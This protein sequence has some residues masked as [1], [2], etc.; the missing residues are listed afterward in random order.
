MLFSELSKIVGGEINHLVKDQSVKDLIYDSR[1]A[2]QGNGSLFFVSG[3]I[4]RARLV[5]CL[6]GQSLS[7]IIVG[8]TTVWRKNMKKTDRSNYGK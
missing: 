2:G 8:G 3:L 4:C 6:F 5:K 1:K 7:M